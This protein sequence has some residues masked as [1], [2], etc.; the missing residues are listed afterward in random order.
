[1]ENF[2]KLD[3][4]HLSCHVSTDHQSFISKTPTSIK[5]LNKITLFKSDF[6]FF[7]F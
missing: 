6:E 4:T 5:Y 7:F 3:G 2:I 1:M